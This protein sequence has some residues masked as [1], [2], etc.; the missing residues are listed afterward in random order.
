MNCWVL[1]HV[2]KYQSVTINGQHNCADSKEDWPYSKNDLPPSGLG[3]SSEKLHPQK[4]DLILSL[5][6]WIFG[7]NVGIKE[8]TKGCTTLPHV[9]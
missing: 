5:V 7:E 1:F 8:P 9:L 6:S 2:G 4:L 3:G